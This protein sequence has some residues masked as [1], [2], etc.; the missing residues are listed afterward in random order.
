MNESPAAEDAG[1]N[2]EPAQGV[3]SK[4]NGARNNAFEELPDELVVE[5]KQWD[6]YAENG[7]VREARVL[8]ESLL[9]KFGYRPELLV[10][11]KRMEELS[12]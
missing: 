4:G 11:K 12:E 6:F 3:E 1:T 5:L 9:L 7:F 2:D 10:R 8:L